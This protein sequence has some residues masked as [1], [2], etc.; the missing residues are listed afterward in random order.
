MS[1][2]KDEQNYSGRFCLNSSWPMY[3]NET[4]IEH[5]K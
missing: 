2:S 3:E 5:I 1:T 4:F